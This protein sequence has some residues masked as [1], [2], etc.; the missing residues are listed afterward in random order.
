[1]FDYIYIYYD[2]LLNKELQKFWERKRWDFQ[3][4]I[5][6]FLNYHQQS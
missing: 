5:E 2:K 4:I 3:I 1:M 6:R